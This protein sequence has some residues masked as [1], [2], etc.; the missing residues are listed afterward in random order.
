MYYNG[1]IHKV[2]WYREGRPC[3]QDILGIDIISSGKEVSRSRQQGE[4]VLQY[5]SNN[6]L[7]QVICLLE[8]VHCQRLFGGL[9]NVGQNEGGN[10]MR[11]EGD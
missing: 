2:V 8:D 4:L 3:L 7:G 6:S 10:S 11:D 1:V 5:Q 9:E